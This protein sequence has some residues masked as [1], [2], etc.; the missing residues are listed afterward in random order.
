MYNFDNF[1]QNEKMAVLEV[2]FPP[3][4]CSPVCNSTMCDLNILIS[5]LNMFQVNALCALRTR[6][7]SVFV[8]VLHAGFAALQ[9]AIGH[10]LGFLLSQYKDFINALK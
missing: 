7:R 4:R 2:D 8:S 6:Q 1:N 5:K 10:S 3:K 9:K